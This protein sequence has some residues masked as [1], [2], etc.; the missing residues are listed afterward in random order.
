MHVTSQ[1]RY[2]SMVKRSYRWNLDMKKLAR[3]V[4]DCLR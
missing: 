1:K 3:L 2:I 4:V